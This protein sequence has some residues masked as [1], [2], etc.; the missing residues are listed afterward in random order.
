MRGTHTG[1]SAFAQNGQPQPSF[2][3]NAPIQNSTG[4]ATT[5]AAARQALP[6]PSFNDNAAIAG[7]ETVETPSSTTASIAAPAPSFNG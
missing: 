3:D 7:G 2:Q 4:Y 6:Q 1:V 5:T